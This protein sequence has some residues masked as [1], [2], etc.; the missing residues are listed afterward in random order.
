MVCLGCTAS[1][2]HGQAWA[3]NRHP[4]KPQMSAQTRTAK[5][6]APSLPPPSIGLPRR[7]SQSPQKCLSESCSPGSRVQP[8]CQGPAW[9]RISEDSPPCSPA[10]PWP[11]WEGKAQTRTWQAFPAKW[12]REGNPRGCLGWGVSCLRKGL[13][14]STFRD[15]R[16][17]AGQPGRCG[18]RGRRG[19]RGGGNTRHSPTR[20]SQAGFM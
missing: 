20:A 15:S 2:R 18:G 4:G 3:Q 11:C 13:W 12:Q 14:S 8:G 16:G 17:A 6:R 9:Q 19:V 10:G 7:L 5:P 1:K